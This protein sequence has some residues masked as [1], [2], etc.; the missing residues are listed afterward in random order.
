VGGQIQ[1][2]AIRYRN[3]RNLEGNARNL[4]GMPEILKVTSEILKYIQIYITMSKKEGATGGGAVNTVLTTIRHPFKYTYMYQF[5]NLAVNT[6]KTLYFPSFTD[7]L[8]I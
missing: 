3:S 7:D 8:S 4:M 6:Y 1:R 2:W 5:T